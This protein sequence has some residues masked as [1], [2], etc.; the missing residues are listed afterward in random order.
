MQQAQQAEI[1]AKQEIMRLQSLLQ[2]KIAVSSDERKREIKE[3]EILMTQG[4]TLTNDVDFSDD[5]IL[6]QE[7]VQ[8]AQAQEVQQQMQGED[9]D[10]ELKKAEGAVNKEQSDIR[11]GGGGGQPQRGGPQQKGGPPQQGRN[12]AA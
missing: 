2:E 5:S 6:I 1:A 10:K 8:Q 4:N 12:R 7:E 3:R 9:E 11:K